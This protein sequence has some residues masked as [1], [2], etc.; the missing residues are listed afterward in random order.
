M[1]LI[2]CVIVSFKLCNSI[3][4]LLS[5]SPIVKLIWNEKQIVLCILRWKYRLNH[6]EIVK[7][8]KKWNYNIEILIQNKIM[9]SP[10]PPHNFILFWLDLDLRFPSFTSFTFIPKWLKK[11]YISTGSLQHYR[12]NL[13]KKIL[14]VIF[15]GEFLFIFILRLSYM[16]IFRLTY[17]AYLI[18]PV[19]LTVFVKNLE[20]NI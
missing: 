3:F 4:F 2:A 14:F 20:V 16:A 10:P 13:I 19:L 7:I 17:T 6:L 12:G 18:H 8:P 15:W 1:P 11:Y 9:L 5:L